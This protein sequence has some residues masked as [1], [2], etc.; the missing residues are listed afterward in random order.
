LTHVECEQHGRQRQDNLNSAKSQTA[1]GKFVDVALWK[2]FDFFGRSLNHVECLMHVNYD[3]SSL[4]NLLG[5]ETAPLTQPTS[6]HH[7]NCTLA[8]YFFNVSLGLLI[9]IFT[10]DSPG[11]K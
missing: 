6:I 3:K 4:E 10:H 11:I 2:D 9:Q 1:E 5:R 8:D 7:C